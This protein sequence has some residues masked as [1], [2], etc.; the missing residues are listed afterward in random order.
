MKTYEEI[1]DEI[2]VYQKGKLLKLA[3]EIIPNIV[4]DDLMQPFDFP[5][6]EKHPDFRYEEGILEGLQTAVM[7]LRS[8]GVEIIADEMTCLK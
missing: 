4:E 3:K 7:A 8:H 1:F 2:I 5:V 6:L